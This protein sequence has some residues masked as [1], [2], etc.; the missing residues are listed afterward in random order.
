MH[1]VNTAC[2]PI[3]IRNSGSGRSGG[4]GGGGGGGDVDTLAR[5]D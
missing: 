3:N 4:G 5:L 1:D 2:A